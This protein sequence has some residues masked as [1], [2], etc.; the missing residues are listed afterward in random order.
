MNIASIVELCTLNPNG[1]IAVWSLRLMEF[2]KEHG[3]NTRIFSYG[4]GIETSL[5]KFMIMY[6]NFREIFIYPKLAKT[7]FREME[8]NY[9][10]FHAMS[11]HTLSGGRPNMPTMIS[12]HYLVSRQAMMLGRYLPLKYRIYFNSASYHLFRKHERR[13]LNNADCITVSRQAYKDYLVEKMNIPAEKIEIVKYGIDYQFFRPSESV[14]EKEPTAIYVGRGSLPKGFDTLV[15]AAPSMKGKIV[16]VAAQIPEF[17]QKK[18]NEL[19]NIEVVSGISLEELRQRYQES[20]VFIMP[21]LTEGSPISTLEAMACG[22]PVV[23]TP[24]GS[25]EYIEDGVNGYIFDFK[26][27]GALAEKVNYLFD[28]KKIAYEFGALNRKKVENELTLNTIGAQIID[29]YKKIST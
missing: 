29:L 1:G 14:T 18:I 25:G 2:L 9:D 27:S 17:L 21:S 16:A 12:I 19:D 3:L 11:P 7:I 26:D 13:G 8:K 23:C 4:D 22:L 20:L 6:P 10:V 15:E 5:P 24:E 28:N